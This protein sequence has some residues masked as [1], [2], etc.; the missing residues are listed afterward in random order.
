MSKARFICR[1]I[2]SF[3]KN[4]EKIAVIDQDGQRQTTYGDFF[5]MTLR[6]AGYLQSRE[7]TPHSFIPV[8]LPT[9]MDYLASEIGVWLSGHATVPMSNQFPQER[10]DYMQ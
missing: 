9:S 2:E 7:L 10:I 8:C 1:L 4:H 5:T 6:V 3:K